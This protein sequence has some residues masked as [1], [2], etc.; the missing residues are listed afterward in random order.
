MSLSEKTPATPFPRDSNGLVGKAALTPAPP[1]LTASAINELDA[2]RW[3]ND[4]GSEPSP[5]LRR[6]WHESDYRTL[7]RKGLV[8]WTEPPRPF[9]PSRWA[10]ATITQ[11]GRQAL[12]AIAAAA[13][14]SG[15]VQQA[16]A[17]SPQSGHD[18][19]IAQ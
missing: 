6:H 1:N 13:R 7:V 12:D 8:C 10:G 18:S 2:L 4:S 19:G 14:E 5:L 9:S 16:P 17:E 3:F 11:A 15:D